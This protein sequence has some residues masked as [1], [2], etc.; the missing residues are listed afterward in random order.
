MGG[1]DGAL[2]GMIEAAAEPLG[3]AGVTGYGPCAAEVAAADVGDGVQFIKSPGDVIGGEEAVLPI[4]DGFAGAE[5]IEIDGDVNALAS[6]RL[7]EA[8]ESGA[9]V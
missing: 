4:G 2:A 1:I 7:R 3:E 6:Q 5:G 9:P 8:G